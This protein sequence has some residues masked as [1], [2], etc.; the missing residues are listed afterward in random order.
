MTAEPGFEEET[1]LVETSGFGNSSLIIVEN[2][3]VRGYTGFLVS[4]DFKR[5]PYEV[6]LLD[7]GHY[8]VSGDKNSAKL[9]AKHERLSIRRQRYPVPHV[10]IIT[11]SRTTLDFP[12]RRPY[13]M[14]LIQTGQHDTLKLMLDSEETFLEGAE[15][16]FEIA[17]EKSPFFRYRD[18]KLSMPSDYASLKIV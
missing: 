4:R 18:G 7:V 13:V 9:N 10:R 16:A 6:E 8:R 1:Q 11:D 17:S 12:S 15:M 3:L 2:P 5:H 14:S